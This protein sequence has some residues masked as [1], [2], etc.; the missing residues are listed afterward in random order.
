MTYSLA[1]KELVLPRDLQILL[2]GAENSG[3][4]CLVSTFLNEKFVEGQPAT[5][6]IEVVKVYKTY[7]KNWIKIDHTMKTKLLHDQYIGQVK[8][9]AKRLSDI[10]SGGNLMPSKVEVTSASS[11]NFTHIEPHPQ[12]IQDASSNTIKYDQTTLNIALLDFAGQNIY[13]NFHSVFISE[14]GVPVITFNASRKLGDKVIPRESYPEPT[15]CPTIISN[16]QYW[17]QVI[18]S[19]CSVKGNVLLVGTHLDMIHP[20]LKKAHTIAKNTIL[21]PLKEAL[22]EKPYIKCLFGYHNG[23]DSALEQ[24]CFFLSNKF[25]NEEKE[26]IERLKS[27]AIKAATSLTKEQPIFFLKIERALLMCEHPIMLKHMIFDLVKQNFSKMT[28]DSSEFEK[29]V[30]HFHDKRT[31]LYFSQITFV[32][33]S[34]HWLTKHFSYVIAKPY[35]GGGDV[36]KA[37]R[38]LKNYG[39]LEDKLLQH[40]LERFCSDFPSVVNVTKEQVVHILQKFHLIAVITREA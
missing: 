40:M 11:L 3:K 32:I 19:I 5:E 35:K 6:G 10:K 20:D 30:K 13:H 4:T 1:M 17:L 18:Y 34:P 26:E 2:V 16:I 7:S 29:I 27:T 8:D 21:R 39:I 9:R 23:L 31:I 38:R 36:D 12:D 24:C 33:L 25:P 15:E 14:S 22:L 37:W 28:E